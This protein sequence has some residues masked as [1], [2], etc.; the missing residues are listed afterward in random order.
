MPTGVLH[1][2]QVSV[3]DAARVL[4][5]LNA[6]V[7]AAEIAEM[8]GLSDGLSAG[9]RVGEAI[10]DQRTADGPFLFLDQVLDVTGVN[11]TRFTEIVVALSGARP[12]APGASLKI[13]PSTDSLWL[14]QGVKITAQITDA[15]GIGIPDAAATFIVSDGCLTAPAGLQWQKGRAVNLT[16]ETGGIFQ[17]TIDS[18]FA[19]PLPYAAQTALEGELSRLDRNH[20]SDRSMNT[21][22]LAFAARYRSEGAADLRT[23][24]D[25]LYEAYPTEPDNVL[26]GWPI[27]PISLIGIAS[28]PDGAAQ[29][30]T[31]ATLEFRNWL[32][33]WRLA[34]SGEIQNDTRMGDVLSNLNTSAQAG[35]D[36]SFSIATVAG[37]FAG[38]E[39]GVLGRLVSEQI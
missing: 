15:E 38:M 19:P 34:L 5:F 16:A 8:I 33:R 21:A 18:P 3:D 13:D 22:L 25:R 23:A 6:A 30:V 12:A 10:L 17:F 37:A 27:V 1:P 20:N 26:A 32:G 29:V 14:G 36:V 35:E 24:V 9:M 2:N 4:S 28:G 7:S 31:V 39:Q 11:L